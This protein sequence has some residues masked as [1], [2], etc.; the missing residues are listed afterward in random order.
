MQLFPHD[1]NQESERDEFNRQM[2]EEFELVRDFI[3]LHYHAT[4]R[5]D[6]RFWRHVSSM[7]IPET[8]KQKIKLFR[9]TGNIFQN[10]ADVFGENSWSQVMLGQ[11]IMP[12]AY[13]PIVDMMDDTELANFLRHHQQRVDRIVS[14]LPAHETFLRQYCSSR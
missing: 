10:V 7:V 4:E 12:A 6:T 9:Q 5:D 1:G 14:S 2:H 11:G 3:I 8:L 13:H